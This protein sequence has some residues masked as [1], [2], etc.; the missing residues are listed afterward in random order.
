[1]RVFD[2]SIVY[3][4]NMSVKC[5]NHKEKSFDD[6]QPHSLHRIYLE[7]YGV[8]GRPEESVR[9][10]KTLTNKFY[11]DMDSNKCIGDVSDSIESYLLKIRRN[12]K[13][14]SIL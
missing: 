7:D 10:N 9:G 5:V 1:M 3:N 12:E 4:N 2:V 11:I 14:E 13:I 6:I 8:S